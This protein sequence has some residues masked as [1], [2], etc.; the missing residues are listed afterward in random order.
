MVAAS[1]PR[2]VCRISGDRIAVSIAGWA[3]ANIR[4]KRSSGIGADCSAIAAISSA[5]NWRWPLALAAVRRRRAASIERRRATASSQA[6]GLRGAPL[7]GHSVSAAAKAS[8]KASSAPA[9]SRVRALRK[10]TKRP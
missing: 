5:S 7:F 2:I 3:Q 9:T 4:L 1:K 8:D 10:A 6:S